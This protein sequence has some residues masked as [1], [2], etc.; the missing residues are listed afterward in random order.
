MPSEEPV[1]ASCGLAATAAPTM[2]RRLHARV[3]AGD[4]LVAA[5]RENAHEREELAHAEEPQ[6]ELPPAWPQMSPDRQF[7]CRPERPAQK[8]LS[9]LLAAGCGTAL[10][11][12]VAS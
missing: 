10:R 1:V 9:N 5:D 3:G 6:T 7:P 12:P 4:G 8:T 11:T 2:P